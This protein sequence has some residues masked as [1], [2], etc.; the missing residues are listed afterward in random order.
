MDRILETKNSVG[1]G[2]GPGKD[3][4]IS[5]KTYDTSVYRVTGIDQIQDIIDC[6]YVRPKENA[7]RG[8]IVYWAIGGDQL[9]YYDRRPVIEAPR[10]LVQDGQIGAI[11]LDDLTGIWIFDPTINRY[12]NNLEE[13]KELHSSN[14]GR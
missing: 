2:L 3:N 14:R 6:G 12:I 9:Y 1:P 7:A 13:V 5:L 11:S 8:N 10:E 4:P